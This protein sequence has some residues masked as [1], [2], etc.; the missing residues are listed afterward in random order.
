MRSHCRASR[1]DKRNVPISIFRESILTTVYLAQ[2]NALGG[3]GGVIYPL[4]LLDFELPSV[5]FYVSFLFTFSCLTHSLT[6]QWEK[7]PDVSN[8]AWIESP[9]GELE[10]SSYLSLVR[11][12]QVTL[13]FGFFSYKMVAYSRPSFALTFCNPLREVPFFESLQ[14]IFGHTNNKS[15]SS[16]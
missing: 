2:Y 8:G 9:G 6:K 7:P 10:A 5:K 3:G 11:H 14:S 15:V 16:L 12:Q 1:R 13:G 4:S